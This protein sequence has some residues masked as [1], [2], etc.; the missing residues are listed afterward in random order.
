ML[1]GVLAARDAG[2]P[3]PKEVLKDGWTY[4]EKS[5]TARGGV[6]YSLATGVA[7]GS[8]RPALTAAAILVGVG[9]AGLQ[10]PLV[11][12]WY[13][14]CR[15]VMVLPGRVGGGFDDYGLYHWSQ[16]VALL[17]DEG[18]AKLFPDSKPADRVSW[19]KYREELFDRLEKTQAADGSWGPSHQVSPVYAAAVHLIML[20]LD[21]G[22]VPGVRR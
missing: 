3:I 10:D 5:T 18:W 8:E 16:A 1:L 9:H 12:K 14:F 11:K 17:G 22:P 6:V 19:S 13:A 15:P 21:R 2:I 7:A 20:Q 4:L